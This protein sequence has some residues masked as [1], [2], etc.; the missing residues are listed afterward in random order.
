MPDFPTSRPVL[1]GKSA[2][3]GKGITLEALPEGHVLQVMGATTSADLRALLDSAGLTGSALRPAGYRQWYA[4]GD[5]PLDAQALQAIV[6]ALPPGTYLSDQSHGRV[7]IRLSGTRATE[8]LSKGTA[9]D[10]HDS[11]FSVGHTA[12][13]LFGH[14]SVHLSRTGETEFELTVLRSFAEALYSELEELAA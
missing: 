1:A 6:T 11:A 13:T 3:H 9:V 14:I 7:R 2:R 8:L 10:L 5:T 12:T 4:V